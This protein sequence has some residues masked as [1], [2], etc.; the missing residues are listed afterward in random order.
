PQNTLTSIRTSFTHLDQRG[1]ASKPFGKALCY[2]LDIF[3]SAAQGALPYD[4]NPPT[5]CQQCRLGT[6]VVILIPLNLLAPEVRAGSWQL[7][8]WAVVPM[9]EA[10]MHKYYRTVAR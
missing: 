5:V 6:V 9:P 3:P 4:A 7:E 10:S 1:V 2:S 8:Q